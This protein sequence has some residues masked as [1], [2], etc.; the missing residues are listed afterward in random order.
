MDWSKYIADP[1]ERTARLYPALLTISPLV[2]L[3]I[4]VFTDYL[5]LLESTGL[6]VLGSASAF[7]LAQIA[8]DLG[9]EGEKSLWQLWGGM[10]SMAIFRHRDKKLNSIIKLRYH[11]RLSQKLKTE[12]PTS[13]E[14]RT[15]P[16]ATDLIY[17]AWSDYLRSNTR[18][19]RFQ[20][21]HKENTNYGYR[22][23]VWGLRSVGITASVIGSSICAIHLYYLFE[24][25]NE[26]DVLAGVAG[27]F[28]LV[29]LILWLFYFTADWVRIPAECYAERLCEAIE[30]LLP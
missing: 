15:D 18:D 6:V 28:C 20:L 16:H 13:D 25:T 3:A 9:K 12:A 27:T 11:Q 5:S 10:P 24:S 8:R 2:A 23:N 21:L 14:E 19:E 22:R 1:Y 29:L 30:I 4:A 7:P 17:A 26:M